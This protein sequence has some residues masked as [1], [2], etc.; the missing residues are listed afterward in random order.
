MIDRLS[1]RDNP[2]L[3]LGSTALSKSFLTEDGRNQSLVCFFWSKDC[4]MIDSLPIPSEEETK[5]HLV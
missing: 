4:I 3:S 2:L 5:S 1:E